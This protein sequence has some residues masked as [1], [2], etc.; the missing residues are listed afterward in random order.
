L[1]TTGTTVPTLG[2]GAPPVE[3]SLPEVPVETEVRAA[4]R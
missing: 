1:G 4:A 2:R 3:E